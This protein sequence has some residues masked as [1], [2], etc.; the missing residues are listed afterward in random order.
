MEK[1][2]IEQ[3]IISLIAERATLQSNYRQEAARIRRE[4]IKL[5]SKLQKQPAHVLGGQAYTKAQ[6][7]DAL[8]KG[9]IKIR[10]S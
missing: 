10:P 6:Y 3:Q 2:L 1:H 7:K 4:L 8:A 9:D 5:R